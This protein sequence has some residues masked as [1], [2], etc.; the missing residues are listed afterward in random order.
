M[1]F[2]ASDAAIRAKS[3]T[4]ARA[5][6]RLRLYDKI[7]CRE[8]GEYPLHGRSRQVDLARNFRES[9]S[10]RSLFQHAQYVR[11]ASNDLHA[12]ASEAVIFA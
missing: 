9:K 5:A 7:L 1:R 6:T 4:D 8:R 10:F 3:G 12:A 11:G 2:E